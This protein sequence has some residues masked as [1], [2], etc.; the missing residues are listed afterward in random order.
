[1]NGRLKSRKMWMALIAMILVFV[2]PFVA[3]DKAEAGSL[4]NA[5][6]MIA[7]VYLGGQGAVDTVNTYKNGTKV[8]AD[9]PLHIV[10][11]DPDFIE[12]KKK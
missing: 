2:S 10:G 6:S 8:H 7:M 12:E 1:M 11:P 4:V 3:G 9:S 5:I